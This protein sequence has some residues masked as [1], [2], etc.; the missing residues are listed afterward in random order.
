MSSFPD[1]YVSYCFK[2]LKT[3]FFRMQKFFARFTRASSS[4][5]FSQQI[6]IQMFLVFYF[7]Y[8]LHLERKKIVSAKQ[9][10][11][12]K[13]Q[14]KETSRINVGFEF[15]RMKNGI[16][17]CVFMGC[18]RGYHCRRSFCIFL[19]CPLPSCSNKPPLY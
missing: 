8:N 16:I 6:S 3:K 14:N 2:V 1:G 18:E 13:T 15:R 17:F 5:K 19:Q 7:P 11:F 12:V 10:I 4:Q 9:F